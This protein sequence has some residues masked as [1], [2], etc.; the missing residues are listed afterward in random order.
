MELKNVNPNVRNVVI[1][2]L[3]PMILFFQKWLK[4]ELNKGLQSFQVYS[5][6]SEFSI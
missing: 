5:S 4:I 3:H 6:L 1:S 2:N